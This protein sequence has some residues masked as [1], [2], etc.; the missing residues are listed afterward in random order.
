[1]RFSVSTG[2]WHLMVW[3]SAT[4]R[5]G[6]ISRSHK[7]PGTSRLCPQRV[8]NGQPLGGDS[9]E[10]ISPSSTT[11][12]F[13]TLRVGDRNRRQE[14]LGIGV[15]R[16]REDL[17]GRAHLDDMAEIHDG[18]PVGEIAHHRQIVADEHHRRL[19]F[20]LQAHQE[21]ADRGLHRNVERRHRLV[22]DDDA[23]PPGEGAR[24]ADALLLAARQLPRASG[25]RRRAAAS[26]DRAGAA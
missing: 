13:F 8:W 25:W 10:G 17:L 2:R 4:T 19:R 14:R 6:G 9:A 7:F 1:M 18:D 5:V 21:L 23:R 3:P 24:N 20:A 12:R 22:G 11:W 16:R 15:E 26:P